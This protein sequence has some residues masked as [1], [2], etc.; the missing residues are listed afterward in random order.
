MLDEYGLSLGGKD[1]KGIKSETKVCCW[2][3]RNKTL[4]CLIE[5]CGNRGFFNGQIE[6]IRPIIL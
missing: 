4:K 5:V 3:K 6:K 1:G 2:E